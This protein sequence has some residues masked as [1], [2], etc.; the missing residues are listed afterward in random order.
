[1]TGPQYTERDALFYQEERR[2]FRLAAEQVDLSEDDL[3]SVFSG[4]IERL[5]SR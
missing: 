2:A 5:L 1:M 3:V 4:N